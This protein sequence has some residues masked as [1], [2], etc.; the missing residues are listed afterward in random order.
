M[1]DIHR[2]EQLEVVVDPSVVVEM[3]E[4]AVQ[5]VEVV[6]AAVEEVAAVDVDGDAEVVKVR[7]SNG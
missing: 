3:E 7:K 2:V 6:E 5:V 1:E 4:A